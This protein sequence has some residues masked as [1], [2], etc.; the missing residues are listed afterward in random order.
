MI[1]LVLVSITGCLAILDITMKSV[2]EGYLK[3]GEERTAFGGKLILRK[4]YN[5]GFCL[6]AFEKK[7]QVVKYASA[8][9]AVLLTIYQLVTLLRKGKFGKKAGLSLM[10]AGA[11]SNTFDRWVR[12]YVIDYVGFQTKREK[13]TALTYNLGDFFIAAGAALVMLSEILHGIIRNLRSMSK[14]KS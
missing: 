2:I 3:Q 5:R 14:K 11:W 4:V 12:G 10:T 9:A 6:N 1:I 7:P 13:T 8:Y